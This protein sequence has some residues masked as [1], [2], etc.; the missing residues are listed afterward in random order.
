MLIRSNRFGEIE[1]PDDKVITFTRP[2]LGFEHLTTFCIIEMEELAPFLWLQSTEDPQ[3][4]FIIV[5]PV[6]FFKNYKIEVNPKEIADIEIDRLE[7]VE[8]Y[9]IVT[10][11]EKAEDMSVNL[12]GPILINTGNCLGRQLVLVNSRYGVKHKIM[13]ALEKMTPAQKPHERELVGA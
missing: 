5:N 6:V 13:E 12:Q 7:A 11:P 1:V 10:F 8:T 2:I 9:V 3:V 4:S